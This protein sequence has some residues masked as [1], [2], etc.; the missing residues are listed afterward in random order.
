MIVGNV[1]LD[2]QTS[3]VEFGKNRVQF[4]KKFKEWTYY[5]GDRTIVYWYGDG[6]NVGLAA[7]HIAETEM[8]GIRD[9]L[10]HSI[11]DKIEIIVYTDLTDLKQSNIGLEDAFEYSGGSTKILD[12]KIF[13]YFDGNHRHL[14]RLIRQGIAGVYIESILY[15]SSLQEIVQNA[16]SF[17][18][19]DW[20][21]SGLIAYVG[22]EWSVN[23]DN[24]L[25]DLL[26]K[27]HIK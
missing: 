10:E 9:L 26:T 6:R 18:L 27:S 2:A 25:R 3:R 20:F 14:H 12:N 15:G 8:D 1:S 17:N 13:L 7:A 21:K 24:E 16:V 19:P 11:S 4:H 5:E 23:L 22:E